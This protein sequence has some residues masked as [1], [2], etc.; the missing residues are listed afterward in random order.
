M[1]SPRSKYQLYLEILDAVRRGI[2]GPTHICNELGYG[3]RSTN[4]I[5]DSM[6][7]MGLVDYESPVTAVSRQRRYR[8][9]NSV[10][11]IW[12][13][14]RPIKGPT[15]TAGIKYQSRTSHHILSSSIYRI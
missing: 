2:N 1:S 6:L 15:L 12:N 3:H 14:P 5:L 10:R 8:L 7:S 13:I 4:G 11:N 9:N